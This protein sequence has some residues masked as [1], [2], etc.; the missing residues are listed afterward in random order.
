MNNNDKQIAE[1][2][3]EDFMRFVRREILHITE[4]EQGEAHKLMA[5]FYG[6]YQLSNYFYIW[7]W[8]GATVLI[9]AFVCG[10]G[11]FILLMFWLD[12][13]SYGY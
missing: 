2:G 11:G 13:R 7:D 3:K 9:T 5:V 6:C 1:M 12:R 8:I 10:I 4:Q